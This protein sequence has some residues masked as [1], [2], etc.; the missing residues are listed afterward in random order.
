[1]PREP[2]FRRDAPK[3]ADPCPAAERGEFEDRDREVP[4]DGIALRQVGEICGGFGPRNFDRPVARRDK[5]GDGVQERGLAGAVRPDDRRQRARCEDA[6]HGLDGD[7]FAVSHRE[8]P[9]CHAPASDVA[10]P[11]SGRI[12]V[13]GFAHPLRWSMAPVFR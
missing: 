9:Q 8:F 4:I 3:G 5:P 2:Q 7:A 13:A 1:M 12:P 10:Q 6:G 11:G